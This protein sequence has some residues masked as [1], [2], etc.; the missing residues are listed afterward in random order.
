MVS[1]FINVCWAVIFFLAA[2]FFLGGAG[3]CVCID[4]PAP[5]ISISSS[6][7]VVDAQAASPPKPGQA[8]ALEIVWRQQY[9]MPDS[10]PP[11]PIVWMEGERLD[12]GKGRAGDGRLIGGREANGRGRAGKIR[13]GKINHGWIEPA[14]GDGFPP[15]VSGAFDP[16]TYTIQLSWPAGTVR[17]STTSFAHELAHARSFRLLGYANH[18]GFDFAPRGRV[19]KADQALRRAGL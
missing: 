13:A 9:E 6:V 18:Q 1:K 17:F 3:G 14:A 7:E 2:L 19:H 15:C 10:A 11:P 12:C 8:K 4:P 5:M 16:A